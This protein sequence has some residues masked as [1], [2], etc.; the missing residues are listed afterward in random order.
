MHALKRL[1][2]SLIT[3]LQ[4]TQDLLFSF[5]ARW[6]GPCPT[7]GIENVSTTGNLLWT[8]VRGESRQALRPEQASHYARTRQ[9]ALPGLTQAPRGRQ[10]AEPGP[11]SACRQGSPGEFDRARPKGQLFLEQLAVSSGEAF[12]R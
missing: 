5:T 6:I 1:P 11:R 9:S 4:N 3:T 12:L 7:Y 2:D 10:P 8:D